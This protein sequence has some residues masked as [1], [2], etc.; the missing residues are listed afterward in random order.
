MAYNFFVLY[1]EGFVKE[2]ER[3][4]PT[5]E[6]QCKLW[7]LFEYPETSKW[8]RLVAITSITVIVTSIFVFCIETLPNF[9]RFKV[10]D[11]DSDKNKS[12]AII[13]DDIPHLN[14][15]FFMIETVCIVWFTLELVIRLVASTSASSIDRNF[16]IN[17]QCF[18][19]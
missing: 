19:F 3:I 16:T 4:L 1:F 14:E 11:F 13:E 10:V 5:N 6:L 2:E 18:M 17:K 15:P 9:K 8:A 12:F 7:L